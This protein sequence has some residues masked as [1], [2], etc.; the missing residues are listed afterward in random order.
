MGEK[1][2]VKSVEIVPN[3]GISSSSEDVRNRQILRL[4]EKYQRR[5]ERRAGRPHPAIQKSMQKRKMYKSIS[6]IASANEL[7]DYQSNYAMQSGLTP[8]PDD[9]AIEENLQ[10]GWMRKA[11]SRTSYRF[12]RKSV[13]KELLNDQSSNIS[14]KNWFND[15]DK[16][17]Q[18]ISKI[19]NVNNSEN[20]D[21][22]KVW[23]KFVDSKYKTWLEED[24][25][26][27]K[28]L[29]S[30]YNNTRSPGVVKNGDFMSIILSAGVSTEHL[31]PHGVSE[32]NFVFAT[33]TD[34]DHANEEAEVFRIAVDD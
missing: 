9:F 3:K 24:E 23:S 27:E 30:S 6:N 26:E 11:P 2:V 17:L 19:S 29:L 34:E 7:Q 25:Q 21:F 12:K 5:S 28:E 14:V 32:R 16:K 20:F 22:E 10:R 18:T 1:R 13:A 33:D 8:L 15:L 4:M 31:K